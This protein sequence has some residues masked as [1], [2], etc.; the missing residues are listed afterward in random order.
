MVLCEAES[1]A[2]GNQVWF[3]FEIKTSKVKMVC[4]IAI[5]GEAAFRLQ[6]PEKCWLGDLGPSVLWFLHWPK[7]FFHLKVSGV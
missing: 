6:K 5:K 4:N 3:L 1:S 7:F 2:T